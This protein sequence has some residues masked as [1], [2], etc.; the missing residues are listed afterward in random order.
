MV[1][2]SFE[3]VQKLIKENKILAGHDISSGGVLTTLLE[4]CFAQLDFGANID[5]NALEETD[6]IKVLFAENP[7]I[8]IQASADIES[9]LTEHNLHYWEIGTFVNQIT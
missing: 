4:M 8:I 5:F 6:T 7:G 3:T 9:E 2:R 1:K